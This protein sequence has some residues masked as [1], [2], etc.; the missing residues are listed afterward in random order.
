MYN[1]NYRVQKTT[2]CVLTTYV[3]FRPHILLDETLVLKYSR[4][5]ENRAIEDRL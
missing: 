5:K 1:N 4:A 2:N 3:P